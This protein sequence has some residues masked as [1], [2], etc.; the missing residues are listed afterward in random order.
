VLNI[1]AT[2]GDDGIAIDADLGGDLGTPSALDHRP[3]SVQQGRST[4]VD[5]E[6]A[7]HVVEGLLEIRVERCPR[8]MLPR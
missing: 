5:D 1:E 4:V 8:A 2:L 3:R 7:G 6:D